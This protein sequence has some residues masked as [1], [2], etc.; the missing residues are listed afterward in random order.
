MGT[1]GRITT[2]WQDILNVIL[3]EIIIKDSEKRVDEE[4]TEIRRPIKPNYEIRNECTEYESHRRTITGNN[5]QFP[6]Q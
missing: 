2:E 1:G 4:M 3:D 6:K 5:R